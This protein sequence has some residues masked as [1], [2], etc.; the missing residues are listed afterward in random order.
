MAYLP[1]GEIIELTF[2][3]T[4]AKVNGRNVPKGA[5]IADYSSKLKDMQ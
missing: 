2:M 4:F 3:P 1:S 5:I